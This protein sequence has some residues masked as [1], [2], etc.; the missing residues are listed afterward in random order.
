MLQGDITCTYPQC[1]IFRRSLC[2]KFKLFPNSVN[3]FNYFILTYLLTHQNAL[4]MNVYC[5]DINY[6]FKETWREIWLLPDCFRNS[7]HNTDLFKYLFGISG[8]D[9]SE[10]LTPEN[11]VPQVVSLPEIMFRRFH[12]LTVKQPSHR[13]IELL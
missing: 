3:Y 4:S 2:L 10:G 7:A 11:K 13:N 8:E 9:S 1:S 12:I 6:A 5:T